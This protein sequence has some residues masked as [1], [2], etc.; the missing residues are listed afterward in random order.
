M[1]IFLGRECID[2]ILGLQKH[3]GFEN[4]SKENS[5]LLV[6]KKRIT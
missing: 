3:G 5:L 2:F 1:L 6:W 4:D